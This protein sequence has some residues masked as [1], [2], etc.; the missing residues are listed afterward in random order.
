MTTDEGVADADAKLEGALE[1]LAY[2]CQGF[3][4]PDSDMLAKKMM[5]SPRVIGMLEGVKLMLTGEEVPDKDVLDLMTE[6]F[7]MGVKVGIQA[8]GRAL[9]ETIKTMAK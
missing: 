4:G 3:D 7:Q 6:A 1:K 9:V 2:V 8:T 5:E